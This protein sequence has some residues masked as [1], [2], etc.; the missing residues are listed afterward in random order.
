MPYALNAAKADNTFSGD[1]NDLTNKPILTGDVTGATDNTTV[2]KIQGLEV[3]TN[4]PGDG[5]ILK[6]D[7]A[8]SKWIPADDNTVS[9][10]GVDGVVT[11]MGVSGTGIKQ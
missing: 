3:S 8:T 4:I 10:S 6:W 9:G 7:N 5:Q 11:S 1:Y 2:E